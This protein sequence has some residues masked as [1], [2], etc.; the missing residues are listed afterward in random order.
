MT[1]R[2]TVDV[3]DDLHQALRMAVVQERVTVTDIS[4]ALYTAFLDDPQLRDRT[5][6]AARASKS[7]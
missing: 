1:T 2:I 3:D 7:G 6:R 4:R 5:V